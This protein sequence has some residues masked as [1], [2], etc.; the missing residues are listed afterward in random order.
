[1]ALEGILIDFTVYGRT[2]YPAKVFPIGINRD[3]DFTYCNNLQDRLKIILV[4]N[5]TGVIT[6]NSVKVT[7]FPGYLMTLNSNDVISL[8]S[9]NNLL[10][11]S[12]YFNPII[13]NDSFT[14]ETL[15]N[16][17]TAKLCETTR[18]DYSNIRIFFKSDV[19]EKFFQIPEITQKRIAEL[20]DCIEYEA[21]EQ[22]NK[23]WPCSLR[24]NII[25]LL[26]LIMK[27]TINKTQP[28]IEVPESTKELQ[29]VV[30]YLHTFYHKKITLNSL[31]HEFKTNRTTL[32]DKFKKEFNSTVMTYLSRL[33]INVAAS[34]LRNTQLTVD[35][36]A[37][38]IGFADLSHFS[39]NFKKYM[40][41][42]PSEFRQA[43][44]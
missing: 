20:F 29:D 2:F 13:V 35:D 14:F 39:R 32:S 21:T 22:D 31:A 10:A 12:V 18:H 24:Q 15:K 7:L 26:F 3:E 37:Y 43:K 38:R 25:Q 30:L 19:Q 16:I 23:Y 28:L 4:V 41:S 17:K 27:L 33:R 42:T 40:H 8:H 11:H 44:I 34:L 5:G 1:L 9:N 6:I 36:I